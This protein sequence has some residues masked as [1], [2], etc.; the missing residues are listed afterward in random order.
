M[1]LPIITDTIRTAV[2]GTASNGH[3]F[4]SILHFRKTGVLT[5]AGAIAI[6]DP[7]LLSHINTGVAGGQSQRVF[8]P[9]TSTIDQFRYTPLD[10]S[11]ATTIISHPLTGGDTSD[12]LPSSVA[13]VV[14]TRTAL[15]G[16]SHRGRY[17]QGPWGEAQN[18]A[19]GRPLSTTV[20]QLANQ[21]A[22]LLTALTGTGVSLVVAS[23]LLSSAQNVTT[24]T[25]DQR[26]DTQRRRLNS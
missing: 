26:W 5:F 17:Y 11:S 4:A 16:R 7:I 24:C 10:G 8:A 1:P 21:W 13:L 18:G 23:Y 6:L 2:E 25:I 22:G 19:G 3:K 9:T 14:T 12:P 20:T 15:R